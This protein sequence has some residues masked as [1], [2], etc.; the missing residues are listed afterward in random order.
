MFKNLTD[1]PLKVLDIIPDLIAQNPPS[2]R[3]SW[4]RRLPLR[5]SR[6]KTCARP[7]TSPPETGSSS[8]AWPRRGPTPGATP[9]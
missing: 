9:F 7:Q 5:A 4:R 6:L 1:L 3:H 2:K 8:S